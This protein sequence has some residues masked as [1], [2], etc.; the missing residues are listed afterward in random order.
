[1]MLAHRARA[2]L[3]LLVWS[4]CSGT[5]QKSEKEIT[6]EIS[7]II[8]QITSSV[9]FLP[10]LDQPCQLRYHLTHERSAVDSTLSLLEPAI[11]CSRS[12]CSLL[13]VVVLRCC[14]H[15]RFADL[16]SSGSG[17]SLSVGGERPEVHPALQRSE[18]AIVHHQDS[19]DR[20][21]RRIQSRRLTPRTH[22]KRNATTRASSRKYRRIKLFQKKT[23][24]VLAESIQHPTSSLC[25]AFRLLLRMMRPR[26]A[27]RR[28]WIGRRE[29]L[30]CET[31][32]AI[33]SE[34]YDQRAAQEE[35]FQRGASRVRLVSLLEL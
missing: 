6:K 10:L 9:S 14:R 15:V 30:N 11:V 2:V 3:L 34:Q 32:Y 8:R 22:A 17:D 16:H 27:A 26:R 33:A 19:Q 1:M 21:Q 29:C 7:A 23:P 20:D 12:C 35:R 5:V 18:A 13:F 28:D 4:P 24:A 25:S 31:L